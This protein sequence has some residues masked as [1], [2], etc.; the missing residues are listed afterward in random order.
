L[1][2][3]RIRDFTMQKQQIF[4]VM[5]AIA[6]M[7]AISFSAGAQT[8][9]PAQTKTI[10]TEQQKTVTEQEKKITE[11]QKTVTPQIQQ[12]RTQIL[13]Q[14]QDKGFTVVKDANTKRFRVSQS[15]INLPNMEIGNIFILLDRTV[16]IKKNNGLKLEVLDYHKGKKL[17]WKSS[18]TNVATVDQSGNLTAKNIAGESQLATIIVTSED[19][20]T[21]D[22]CT[23]YVVDKLIAD[24]TA[25]GKGIDITTAEV[26]A[27]SQMKTSP[28]FEMDMIYAKNLWA[29]TTLNNNEDLVSAS[30]ETVSKTIKEFNTK[31]KVSYGGVFSASVSVN[32]K[33][34]NSAVRTSGFT[35]IQAQIRTRDDYMKELNLSRLKEYITDNFKSDL[36]AKDADYMLNIYGSHVVARCYYGGI[37]QLDFTTAS[38]TITSSSELEVRAKAGAF[39]IGASSNNTWKNQ[40][41]DFEKSTNL[42]IHSEGGSLGATNLAQFQQYYKNWVTNIKNGDKNVVCGIDRFNEETMFPLWE[43]AKLINPTKA[44]AIKKRFDEKLANC[45]QI[46]NNIKVYTPVIT[47]ITVM[48]KKGEPITTIP[49]Q[50]NHAVLTKGTDRNNHTDA[51]A[52]S[53]DKSNAYFLD[54]NKGKGNAEFVQIF[55]KTEQREN[56]YKGVAISDI[57]MLKGKDAA[58]PLGYTKL[59]YDLNAGC[60]GKSDFLYLAYKKATSDSDEVIDFIGGYYFD[61]ANIPATPGNDSYGRWEFVKKGRTGQI[62]DLAETCGSGTKFVRLIVHKTKASYNK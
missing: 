44:D 9:L 33:S 56:N 15:T 8:R 1:R 52:A 16:L 25:V 60:G 21:T 3:T 27:F 59:S 17:T 57:L 14:I 50:Y 35:R 62:A 54:C 6:I 30:G 24:I 7:L 42:H 55:Y 29:T 20:T 43:I 39:G 13:Q 41:E 47:D 40:Q 45:N 46:L 58:P 4:R 12:N 23:V 5:T 19:G 10:N 61:S 31:N 34:N 28:V 38:A 22:E 53:A 51:V 49:T 37:V 48:G 32:F 26:F 2:P 11:Q 36:K 18:N